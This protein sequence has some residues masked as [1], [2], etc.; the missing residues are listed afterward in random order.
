MQRIAIARAL[1]SQ[2]NFLIFDEATSELD[3]NSEK[4]IYKNIK[5]YNKNLIILITNHKK[6]NFE[7]FDKI[8][9]LNENAQ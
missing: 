8:L 1:A 2:K 9:Y 6:N 7:T 4:K 3:N 5:Q